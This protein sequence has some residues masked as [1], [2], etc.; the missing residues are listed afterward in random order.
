MKTCKHIALFSIVAVCMLVMQIPF[1]F[2]YSS[3]AASVS[4]SDNS[5]SAEYTSVDLYIRDGSTYSQITSNSFSDG[6]LGYTATTTG[7][8]TTY[9]FKGIETF[10]DAWDKTAKE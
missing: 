6:T 8:V 5:V 9:S 2:A 7:N 4:V 1:A 3:G 10:Q